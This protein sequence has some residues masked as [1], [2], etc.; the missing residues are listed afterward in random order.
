MMQGDGYCAYPLA[1]TRFLPVACWGDRK[2][3]L[4]RNEV[5]TARL[6]LAK[7]IG[8]M[9]EGAQKKL[10]LEELPRFFAS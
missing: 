1:A 10:R 4:V 3:S 8:R 9:Q 5:T 7:R 6:D 2:F